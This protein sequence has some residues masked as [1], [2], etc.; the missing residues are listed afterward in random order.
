[1]NMVDNTN[2]GLILMALGDMDNDKHTDLVTVNSNQDCFTVH[3]WQTEEQVHKPYKQ[4]CLSEDSVIKHDIK[5]ASIVISKDIKEFQSL[6]IVYWLDREQSE[7]TKLK[8]FYQ[9]KRG[10]FKTYDSKSTVVPHSLQDL[11]MHTN[12]QPFFLDINGDMM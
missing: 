6:Y 11:L 1:M 5:I 12:S 7:N 4:T 2:E 8:V 10:V 3:Y 9:P